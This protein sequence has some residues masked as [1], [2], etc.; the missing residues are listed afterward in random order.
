MLPV[1]I[2]SPYAEYGLIIDAIGL[3]E[4]SVASVWTDRDLDESPSE[5]R[6]AP[7]LR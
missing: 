4:V 1:C 3:L 2:R 5:G 7:A 6:Q